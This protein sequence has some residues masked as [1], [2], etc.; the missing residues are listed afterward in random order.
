[1]SPFGLNVYAQEC[2]EK[3]RKI[4]A[5]EDSSQ[6]VENLGD[7]LYNKMLIEKHIKLQIVDMRFS[8]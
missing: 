6:T 8:M 1:M 2:S 7:L 5:K 3:W 4:H